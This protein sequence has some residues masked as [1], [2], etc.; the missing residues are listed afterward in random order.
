MDF[1]I[2]TIRKAVL[3][4]FS[5]SDKRRWVDKSADVKCDFAHHQYIVINLRLQRPEFE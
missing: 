1:G 5:F 2:A 3:V 4:T